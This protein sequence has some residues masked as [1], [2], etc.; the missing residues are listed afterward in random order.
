MEKMILYLNQIAE[1]FGYKYNEFFFSYLKSISKPNNRLCGKDIKVGEGAFRCVDCSLL[2]NT[3]IC[4]YCFNKAK[5]KHKGHN[6]IF[7]PYGN[8]FCDCGDPDCVIKES[9][10]PDHKGP[11]T[12]EK[13]IR[14]YIKTCVDEK[15]LT[16]IEPLLN[17][18]FNEII[19]K[20]KELIKNENEEEI[21]NIEDDLYNMIDNLLLFVSNLYNNN[22]GF[23][24]FVT[25]KFTENYPFKTN[26][27]CIKYY[28]DHKKIIIIKKIH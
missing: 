21:Y 1:V 16:I 5:D 12:N 10:C 4:N 9:F 13:D 11:F 8:G 28:E 19:E 7:K 23:F 6:V 24:L 17:N 18:I 2:S 27:K 14:D 26:H 22:L 15:L 20:I 25:L 3:V